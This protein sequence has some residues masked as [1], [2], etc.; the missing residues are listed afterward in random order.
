MKSLALSRML[1]A[2]LNLQNVDYIVCVGYPTVLH[3]VRQAALLKNILKLR[4]Q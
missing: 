4:L 3:N 1:I 2:S